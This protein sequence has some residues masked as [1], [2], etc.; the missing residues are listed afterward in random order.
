MPSSIWS[1]TFELPE[2][3][4]LTSPISTDVCVVGSGIGGITAAYLLAK[5]GHE[6]TLVTDG[7]LGQGETSKT[8][9]QINT[10]HD[11]SW[12]EM[13]RLHGV[14]GTQLCY[15]AYV[16]ALQF[17]ED[18]V[19]EHSIDCGF[20]F[21]DSYLF[22]APNSGGR[23]WLETE[24]GAARRA[25]MEAVELV[26]SPPRQL[27]SS[28]PA[29]RF[30]RQAQ[31]HP[32]KYLNALMNVMRNE[33]K[34]KV[35]GSTRIEKIEESGEQQKLTSLAGPTITARRVVLAT[36]VPMHHRLI[37]HEAMA[38]YRSYVITVAVPKDSIPKAQYWDNADPY[39][40]VRHLGTAA[41]GESDADIFIV[42]G[43]DHRVGEVE[44][45]SSRFD[46]LERWFRERV[47]S[48]IAVRQR[49]S[50]Q[51]IETFDGMALL[52][53]LSADKGSIFIITGDSGTGMTHATLGGILVSNL[54]S[55]RTLSWGKIFDPNRPRT[56][57]LRRWLGQNTK[58]VKQY[59][60]WLTEGDV[61]SVEAIPFGEGAVLRRGLRKVA[62]YRGPDGTT[63]ECSAT[64]P[65]LGAIV[66]WNPIEKSWDCP[67]HGSRF[68]PEG[69]VLN[70]PAPCG[71]SK[72]S[73]NKQGSEEKVTDEGI[74][75]SLSA[76]AQ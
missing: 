69:K 14:E 45:I 74:D 41:Y 56:R 46:R 36:N 38:P 15:Q 10:I 1:D 71:L 49:W 50:G 40:Y 22:L 54:I 26:S 72:E 65:H 11:D 6:V 3:P 17:I 73:D 60:D 27:F 58:M 29:L 35:Y 13:E 32:L 7:T 75:P 62:V 55:G 20:E 34:V 2:L 52:G 24:I 4:K 64:C 23:E 31:F 53:H 66:R 9:A 25:G 59:Q 61:Q 67:A 37:P 47:P 33:Y 63:H 57:S 42:G 76:P 21:C 19:K 16:A 8:T 48:V 44:G 5:E 51:T 18:R 28:E 70:G 68:T 30:G 12:H 43:E 39:H